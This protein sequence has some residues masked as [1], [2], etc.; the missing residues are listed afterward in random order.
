MVLSAARHFGRWIGRQ[1]ELGAV[2]VGSWQ[3]MVDS[4]VSAELSYP[5]RTSGR[6]VWDMDAAD[7]RMTWT[8][9]GSD[10]TAV[11]PAFAV[12]HTDPHL[13]VTDASG[14]SR[15]EPLG[16]ET[17]YTY[18]LAAFDEALDTGE[19]FLVD[20]DDSVANAELVDTVYRRAGLELRG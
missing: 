12:P 1:P 14:R 13:I 4:S 2:E 11:S 18:Q 5:G 16:T 17:S 9:H 19:P 6:A 20:I 8:V 15:K 3:T 7:R 10:A